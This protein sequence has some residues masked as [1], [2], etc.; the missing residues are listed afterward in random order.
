MKEK[1]LLIGNSA[2]A[3]GIARSLLSRDIPVTL[4][5]KD[6]DAGLP[7]RSLIDSAPRL[8]DIRMNTRVQSCAG[9]AGD[10]HIVLDQGDR[11]SHTDCSCVVIAEDVA[12]TSCISHYGLIPSAHIHTLSDFS[13]NCKAGA[14]SLSDI[15]TAA[16]LLGLA[17]ES[18][19][20]IAQVAMETALNLQRERGVNA[21]IFT[22]NLKV[23]DF[24]LETLYRKVRDVGVTFIKFSDISPIFDQQPDGT[25]DISFTDDI[26]RMPFTLHA[27]M[28]LVDEGTS[29]SPYVRELSRIL[30]LDTD[31]SGFLQADNVHRWS[32]FTNRRG[33]LAVGGSRG[34]FS[35]AAC[36]DDIH[37]AVLAVQSLM[38]DAVAVADPTAEIFSGGCVR[39]LTC[40]R[41]C[42]YHAIVLNTRPV[43]VRDVCER[44]GL[45][46]AECPRKAISIEDLTVPA[47]SQHIQQIRNTTSA[48]A[49]VPMIVVFGCRRSAGQAFQQAKSSGLWNSEGVAVIEIP[50]AGGISLEYLLA[51]FAG[52]ADG[53]VVFTC[54]EGN[55]HSERG[56][57][58]AKNRVEQV[59]NIL[60]NIGM[61]P[62]RILLKTIAANMSAELMQ[63]VQD[64]S[65][66][67][68]DIGADSR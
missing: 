58:M 12:L 66:Q 2:V 48:S 51:A 64:F 53:V 41:L 19:P 11:R 62:D 49:G 6:Q 68:T 16:L 5:I 4:A 24:G 7:L 33:I 44:C 37:A 28:T 34:V 61:K 20:H 46:V 31:A 50:C 56:N 25:V 43:I 52:G 10:F 14:I 27:D 42:P 60:E 45:C 39:C 47:I 63:T 21:F 35:E 18:H 38:T 23:A 67:I 9:T 57:L 32:V 59:R 29:P 22:R 65:R 8:L 40:Y 36:S 1:T 13:Q 30:G 26:T 55:C 17:V 54:H 15:K 3:A